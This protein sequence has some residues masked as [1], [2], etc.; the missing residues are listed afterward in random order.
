MS[1]NT[2]IKLNY[3]LFVTL[4]LINNVSFLSYATDKTFS[5]L[6]IK[7]CIQVFLSCITYLYECTSVEDKL[8]WAFKLYDKDRSGFISRDE[9]KDIFT[10]LCL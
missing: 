6:S 4:L 7:V 2:L 9:M 10:K 1:C 3:S 8:K 5:F